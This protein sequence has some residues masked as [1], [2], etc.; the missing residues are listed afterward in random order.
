[1]IFPVI[2]IAIPGAVSVATPFYITKYEIVVWK[3]AGQIL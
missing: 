3:H 1:M 2:K